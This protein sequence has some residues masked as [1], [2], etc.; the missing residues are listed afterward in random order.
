MAPKKVLYAVQGTGNGH[1]ARARQ[2]LPLLCA[3]AT[4]DV[5][6]GGNQSEVAL[7]VN[8]AFVKQGLVMHYNRKG[9]VSYLKTLFK[10]NYIQ[11]VRDVITAPVTQ[12]DV[13]IND[14]ES[15]TAWACKVRGVRCI[16]L[17]HQAAFRYA[18]TPRPRFKSLLGEAILRWYAP[19]SVY[20][21]FHFR[22]YNQHVYPPVIRQEP[23]P[24]IPDIPKPKPN[25][26][27]RHYE[28]MFSG[29]FLNQQ[30]RR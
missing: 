2:I 26:L 8:P 30:R 5:W 23:E 24:N 25:P 28:A 14:F 16:A 7:P 11:I 1:V 10:N 17:G 4:V 18:E 20:I 9:G 12:Y 6:L 13:V 22:S 27:Q 29:Q 21:G 15:I 19:A 3:V